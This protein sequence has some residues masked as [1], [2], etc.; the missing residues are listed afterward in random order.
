V[1]G[2]SRGI[3]AAT[4][5][6]L[7]RQHHD[8]V[9]HYHKEKA[10][11]AATEKAIHEAGGTAW[12]MKADLSRPREAKRMFTR[13][14]TLTDWE[15]TIDT[16]LSAAFYCAQLV[17]PMML[18]ARW[19]RIVN[20]SSILG[21][22]GS[23]HGAH[24]S[25]SKA[26]LLGLTRSLALELAPHN[27]TV[28]AVTPGAIETDILKSDTPEIRARRLK[29]I[30][31]GRVGTPQEVAEVVAFLASDAAR[32]VTGQVIGVNGGLLTA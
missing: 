15:R 11:A 32:Y 2:A 30:P 1:T 16:N 14:A 3:G 19:G 5:I 20:L 25:S 27:I 10:G 13:I 22:K 24:Y 26:G 6:E 4:A 8:V 9:V 18:P 17:A 23:K 7:A 29:E 28:N 12:V 31:M 21:Q